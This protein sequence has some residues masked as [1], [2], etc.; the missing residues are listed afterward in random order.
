MRAALVV[1][2]GL[3]AAA[4][5]RADG[6]VQVRGVYYKER[7]TRVEQP[8]IDG[9]FD[10]GDGGSLEG[11]VLVDS[12]SSASAVANGGAA[13][14]ERR[15]EGGLGY[16]QRLGRYTI[17]ATA[18][19]ST[20][21]D[22]QSTFLT[23]RGQAELFAR[24][25]TLGLTV[26]GGRDDVSNAGAPDLVQR[27]EGRLETLL[28]SASVTQILGENTVGSITYDLAK[29]DGF[30]QN[31]YRQV[32]IG[33]TVVPE[34]HPDDRVRQAVAVSLRRYLPRT[35]T[36]LIGAYRLYRDDWGIV[37]HTPELRFVQEAGDT[38]EFGAGYR[39]HLQ[40][41]ADFWRE[42]YA[43]LE[44]GDQTYLTD[45]G[46]L[47][48]GTTHQL[49]AKLSV[50]GATFEWEDRWADVRFDFLLSYYLQDNRY[51]GNAGIAH[52]AVTFPI[53]Y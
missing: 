35:G 21:P 38:V 45:D 42:S 5:A 27:I 24:N 22:Y 30:Q 41:P 53:E 37:A 46:K 44:P 26:G 40:G 52:A 16:S 8:M 4:S 31:P 11:H 3:G 2:I 49:T 34:R 29:L 10:V 43:M 47:A 12:I 14:D 6:E 50:T 20:E 13:F 48:D 19:Y 32:V 25:L 15:V 51:F 1:L 28:V 7:A 18:R 23:V 36:A 39:L 17:G 9:R 33:G